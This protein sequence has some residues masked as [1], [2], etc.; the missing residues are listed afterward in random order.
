M[1]LVKRDGR[2]IC[3][4]STKIVNAILKAFE[5]SR[6]EV[7][8]ADVMGYFEELLAETEPAQ[9][10][11]IVTAEDHD[12]ARKMMRA[13]VRL[14]TRMINARI[15]ALLQRKLQSSERTPQSDGRNKARLASVPV[16]PT[17]NKMGGVMNLRPCLQGGLI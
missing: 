2:E 12:N 6:S 17:M 8:E 3:F 16:P 10:S 9:D 1:S 7:S 13:R 11:E 5:S 15:K 14:L 4:D